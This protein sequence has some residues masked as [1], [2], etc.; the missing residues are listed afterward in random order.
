M[1]M[2]EILVIEGGTKIWKGREW[3]RKERRRRTRGTS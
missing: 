3:E 2:L 1:Q